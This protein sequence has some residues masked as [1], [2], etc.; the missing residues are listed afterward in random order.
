MTRVLIVDDKEE[1]LYYLEAL[2][3]GHGLTV[4]SARHGAEALV[5]ARQHAPDVVISDLLMPVMDGYTL[6]RHWKADARLKRVPFIVYTAT[7]TEA[8]DEQLALSLGADAFILKPA[9]PDDFMV[10]LRE[11]QAAGSTSGP[12]APKMPEGD[13]RQLL[14]VYSETLI[15]KLEEKTLQLEET[16]RALEQD[17][18]QRK[19]V[20][21]ALRESEQRFR[22]LAENINEVFWLTDHTKTQMFYV[23]PA[24]ERVWGRSCESLYSAPQSWIETVHPE[25]RPKVERAVAVDQVAG[26]YD[27]VY[28]IVRPDGSVRWVRDR[29]FPVTNDQGQVY[30]LVGTAEDITERREAEER[31]REQAALLDQTQD[32]ILVCDLEHRI[33]S[34]NKGAERIYGWT[35]AE[36]VGR[37]VRERMQ[38]D[39]GQLVEA[40]KS[41]QAT[42]EWSGE[43]RHVTKQG[44]EVI[45]EGRWTLL[46]DAQGQPKSMLAINTDVTERKQ[47]EAQ[48]LRAQRMESIGTLA[49][50][51]AHD[52]N[53]LLAPIMM[54]VDLL[55]FET[56]SPTAQDVINTIERSARRGTDLVKQVLSFARGVEGARV[57]VHLGHIVRELESIAINTFPKNIRVSTDV[58]RELW[59]IQ[60]DPT[61]LNQVVLNLAVNARD[62]MP[63]GGTL[64]F[65][66]S[67]REIDDQFAAM[68]RGA[69]AGRYVVL[70]VAD[71]GCGMKPEVIE[72]IF[73]PFF[74]TKEVGR[75]TGLGLAT[76]LGIV[77]SHGGFVN[78]ES[79]PGRGS[80]FTV[81]LPAQSDGSP[82]EAVALATRDLPRG[83]GET[84]LL[85]DDEASILGISQQTLESFGYRVL[86][87]EDGAQAMGLYAL[88]RST[89]ALVLTDVMMPVMDGVVL[90][91]ALR[92]IDPQVKVI[93]ATGFDSKVSASRVGTLGVGEVLSKPYSA[94]TMLSAVRRV[95]DRPSA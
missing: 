10:R 61:Q 59:L 14:K 86:T 56:L 76:V 35:A 66:L 65:A 85:V 55:R 64:R 42:G 22:Q 11:V 34:W 95:L 20:E 7:Y 18:A 81:F 12:R 8:E 26:R 17:I 83:R 4:E 50:G 43:L 28:R 3:R 45:L 23:S 70:E 19:A 13:E 92:R 58:P 29:A 72:R 67:N 75:G 31:I 27:L 33:L 82:K 90:I 93:A 88:Q 24:Y 15:R 77:R 32:A 36:A 41:L 74:T 5:K 16:N 51:I 30:R 80:T 2:L 6:L 63:G 89:I 79:E 71:T 84:I 9:E 46:R 49:G 52:L 37:L 69:P 73:E 91:N 94:E 53:N 40:M 39:L 1:N 44:A 21:L 38:R 25:D 60:G 48:F 57:A 62:A 87:A 68:N 47:I 78:V 54:A